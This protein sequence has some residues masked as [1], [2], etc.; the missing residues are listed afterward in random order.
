[1][2]RGKI[3]NI[4]F[5]LGFLFI[6]MSPVCTVMTVLNIAA[7]DD[8][9]HFETCCDWTSYRSIN[10]YINIVAIL[11]AIGFGLFL[12]RKTKNVSDGEERAG[13]CSKQSYEYIPTL[14]TLLAFA[15]I[16]SNSLR[17]L[18]AFGI[19]WIFLFLIFRHIPFIYTSPIFPVI[20]Y[21]AYKC[22]I[23]GKERIC[24]SRDEIAEG[25]SILYMRVSE[26]VYY[27]TVNKN[28]K[29]GVCQ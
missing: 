27:C 16:E 14:A 22:T 29:T 8:I 19:L 13:T 21:N 6:Y 7:P 24:I 18:I 1:M 4:L 9:C 25:A 20:G 3:G 28:G 12:Y 5:K 11:Y 15:T 17:G 10:A 2:M 23:D 26:N